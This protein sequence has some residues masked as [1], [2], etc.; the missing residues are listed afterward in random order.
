V[1]LVLGSLRRGSGD[2]TYRVD[3]ARTVWKT[4]RT[5]EGATTLAVR[6][7]DGAG[8]VQARA[9]GP[10]AD[11]VLDGLPML[12]GAEDDPSG[13]TPVH[14]VLVEPS[15][16]YQAWRVCRTRLVMESLVPAVLEQKVTG[17][18]AFRS[19]R[20]LLHLYGEP[21]PGPAAEAGMRV[22]PSPAELRSVPSWGWVRLGVDHK[23]AGT[24]ATVLRAAPALERLTGATHG[25]ADRLL[26]TLPGVGVWTSAEVR[27]RALGDP[28]AVSFGD[29]HV[30]K[31]VGYAL[32]GSPVDDAGMAV[33]LEPYV[34]HR[35]RVQV[36]V[37]LGGLH[38]PRRGP[39]MTL[40][41]HLP[42]GR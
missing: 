32:T 27:A 41:T 15:R 9:W 11:W 39:R 23:R 33:L 14:E 18:E 24:L 38:R 22:M 16:R 21:A 29:F 37:G 8:E 4:F 28:D 13:F 35:L 17:K 2:P 5:P 6:P 40:P 42:V 10:G 7:M 34:G 20:R 26:R 3:A 19:W 25:E 30:A 36:L 1:P 12:L 31:D